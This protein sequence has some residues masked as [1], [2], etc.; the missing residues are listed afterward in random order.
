ME[1]ISISKLLL[2][3]GLLLSIGGQVN[4]MD[5]L[6]KARMGDDIRKDLVPEELDKG[7]IDGSLLEFVK[8]E[9]VREKL[10]TA[11]ILDPNDPDLKD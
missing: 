9:E 5:D 10:N 7:V 8:D 1:R 4:A 11:V 3:T 6:N 2:A